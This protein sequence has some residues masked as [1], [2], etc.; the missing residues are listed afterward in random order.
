L[1]I[2][3]CQFCGWS[4][5]LPCAVSDWPQVL[6]DATDLYPVCKGGKLKQEPLGYI[7]ARCLRYANDSK[8]NLKALLSD[9]R[10][11]VHAIDRFVERQE[12]ERISRDSARLTII[13]LFQ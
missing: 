1:A 2:L 10:V 9:I 11:A 13:K 3:A 8:F 6:R 4:K 7:C 5:A 12:G